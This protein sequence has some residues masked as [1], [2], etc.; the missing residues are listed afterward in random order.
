M[1]VA[2]DH[3]ACGTFHLSIVGSSDIMTSGR[4]VHSAT[5]LVGRRVP[6]VHGEAD[7]RQGWLERLRLLRRRMNQTMVMGDWAVKVAAC[8]IFQHL[9]I[10]VHRV[11][12]ISGKVGKGRHLIPRT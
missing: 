1:F 9:L 10:I 11:N 7:G 6:S 8:G 3:A 5:S 12:I 4:S 2:G